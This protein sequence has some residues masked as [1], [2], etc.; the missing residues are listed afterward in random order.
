MEI[1]QIDLGL[2]RDH[3]KNEEVYGPVL[4][5]AELVES[6][7]ERGVLQPLIVVQ[8]EDELYDIIAGHRRKF[9]ALEAGLDTVPCE[10]REY[11]NEHEEQI[12]LA[13]SN[14]HRTKTQK[15][16]DNEVIFLR[17]ALSEATKARGFAN[18]KQGNKRSKSPAGSNEPTGSTVEKIADMT[19]ESVSSVKRR[20]MVCDTEY[21]KAFYEELRKLG[22]NDELIKECSSQWSGITREYDRNALKVSAAATK[23]K[24]L[25]QEFLELC[26]GYK[27]EKKS[28]KKAV[29]KKPSKPRVE[30]A[31][32]ELNPDVDDEEFREVKE[33]EKNGVTYGYWNNVPAIKHENKVLVLEW[34]KLALVLDSKIAK[35]KKAA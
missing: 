23:V 13:H 2:L 31:T 3:P 9:A 33:D 11:E 35:M 32:L 1:T 14:K 10:V 6:I 27:G 22:A 15:Q 12:D 8:R 21:R 17:S 7:K 28:K 18:L 25:K 26:P 34:D 30:F 19:G 29:K 24:E 4:P 20:T 16:I 5:D